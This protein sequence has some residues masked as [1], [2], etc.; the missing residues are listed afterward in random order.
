M[1]HYIFNTGRTI[2]STVPMTLLPSA[3]IQGGG[4]IN[5]SIKEGDW[6]PFFDFTVTE[7]RSG[8]REA[9]AVAIGEEGNGCDVMW[10]NMFTPACH[11]L[12]RLLTTYYFAVCIISLLPL[13][14]LFVTICPVDLLSFLLLLVLKIHCS[15]WKASGLFTTV[16]CW[17]R[18]KHT[19][20]VF[21]TTLSHSLFL[22]SSVN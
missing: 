19:A 3:T 4:F 10:W 18:Y 20:H 22:F 21:T 2:T 12:V 1:S 5:R 17:F 14:S 13:L 11:F 16:I 7:C 8:A 15:F 9:L 6:F